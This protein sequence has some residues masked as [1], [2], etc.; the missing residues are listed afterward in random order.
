MQA[1]N[2]RNLGMQLGD[3]QAKGSQDAYTQ[4]MN[5]L[6]AQRTSGLYGQLGGSAGLGSI[7][8]QQG[9]IQNPRSYCQSAYAARHASIRR[10]HI[11]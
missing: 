11:K 3:I 10:A 2:Q 9:N 8:T 7:G 1:E 5:A 4:A 6:Q